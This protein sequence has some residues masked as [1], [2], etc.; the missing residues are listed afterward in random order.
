[1][2]LLFAESE[3]LPTF[4]NLI[5]GLNMLRWRR[6]L[7]MTDLLDRSAGNL[8]SH[9]VFDCPG[10][11]RVAINAFIEEQEIRLR[12]LVRERLRLAEEID[13]FPLDGNGAIEFGELIRFYGRQYDRE[14]NAS[15]NRDTDQILFFLVRIIELFIAAF[16]PLLC[17]TLVFDPSG[18]G[19]VFEGAVFDQD[20][21]LLARAEKRLERHTFSFGSISRSRYQDIRSTNKTA[22]RIEAEAF[23]IVTDTLSRLHAIARKLTYHLTQTGAEGAEDGD[24]NAQD[25]GRGRIA[26]GERVI[27]GR[28]VIAG[29]TVLDAL[30][31]AVRIA[32][33]IGLYL[34]DPSLLGI[35]QRVPPLKTEFKGLMRALK[36]IAPVH[37][38]NDLQKRYVVP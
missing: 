2:R 34:S 24:E 28:G 13:F 18:S 5:L 31:H 25:Y 14:T 22:T 1:V 17:E 12:D 23:S 27:K 8:V 33:A 38:F 6:F 32:Y 16:R 7:V 36:R 30:R 15:W 4:G 3:N 26:H 11:V 10:Q 20:F 21:D 9:V 35:Y 29:K 37:I 19:D